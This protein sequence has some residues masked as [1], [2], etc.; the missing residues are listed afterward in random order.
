MSRIFV[1]G[2]INIE[3]TLKVDQFP[4][5]YFPVCYP[6]FGINSSVS[7]VGYNIS[8]ALTTLNNDVILFSLIGSDIASQT[9]RNSLRIDHIDD[10]LVINDLDR[11]AQSVIL[12]DNQ[13]KR[14]IHTDLKDIQEH[15][16][17]NEQAINQL[18]TCD[19]AIL[20]DINFARPYLKE[21]KEFGIPIATDAHTLMNIDDEFHREFL[22]AANIVFLSDEKL[23]TSPEDFSKTLIDCFGIQVVVVGLGAKG[24]QLSLKGVSKSVHV[25]AVHTRPIVNTIGAGD[26]LFSCFLHFFLKNGDALEALKKAVVFASYKI[27]EVGAAEGFLNEESLNLWFSKLEEDAERNRGG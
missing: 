7:G 11:T 16:E 17:P 13:G 25:P 18:R 20:C 6:F 2:L 12:Y 10:R 4:I 5:P 14:Q 22:K 1:A 19:I 21:A 3:T 26:A 15:R 9:I 24:A 23:P 8:K 27:G